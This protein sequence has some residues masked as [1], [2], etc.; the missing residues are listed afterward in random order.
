MTAARILTT[1]P[2]PAASQPLRRLG[3]DRG[4]ATVE[5]AVFVLPMCVLAVMLVLVCF[6]VAGARMDLTSTAAAAA[7]AASLARSPQAATD[8]ANQAAT[9]NLAGHG[10]TCAPMTVTVDTTNFR[11]GGQVAVTITCTAHTGDLVGARLPGQISGSATAYAVI[12]T[13]REVNI[14]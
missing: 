14:G 6:R 11:P 12:D 8:A 7:R 4:S 13:W 2:S 9:T 1:R 3:G 5:Y 10:L